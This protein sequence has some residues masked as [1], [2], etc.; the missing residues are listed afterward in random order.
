MS[1][2]VITRNVV[3]VPLEQITISKSNMRS[4]C[5]LEKINELA[6]SVNRIGQIYPV[7]LHR[8]RENKYEL[9]IGSRR[10]TAARKSRARSIPATVLDD[11]SNQ[12]MVILSL[13]ENLHRN[14]LTPF[15]EARGILRLC[16]EHEMEPREVAKRLH[17]P[18]HWVQ[19]RLKI[20]S[21]PESVQKLLC[22]SKVTLNHVGI[23]ASLGKPRDQIRYAKVVARQSLS[24]EDLTTLIREEIKGAKKERPASRKLFTPMRTA[25]KVKS[26]S[27]FLRNKVRPQLV[28]GGPEAVE[29]RRAL[30]EVRDTIKELLAGKVS[31]N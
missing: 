14:D 7:L 9:V 12:E 21:V 15:E 5:D 3:D 4:T 22:E 29:V 1:Q 28:L 16:K 23:L 20:L 25:L 13:T 27:R 8:L 30:R 17:K 18:L 19:G 10:F 31:K 6:S 2:K 24:E 26:F 11:I